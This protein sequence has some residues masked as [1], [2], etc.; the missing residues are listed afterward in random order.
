MALPA[1]PRLTPGEVP[2]VCACYEEGEACWGAQL[3]TIGDWRHGDVVDLEVDGVRLRMVENPAWAGLRAGNI[4]ALLPV[5]CPIPPVAVM[6]DVPAVYGE[7]GPLLVDLKQIPGRGV[8]VLGDWLRG[9]LAALQGGG[10]DFDDL[11]RGMDR[12][13]MYQG[14]G[15]QPAFPTPTT[16]AS[17]AFPALPASEEALLVRTCFEDED[18][19]RALLDQFGGVD[20]RGRIGAGVEMNSHNMNAF[21]L[22]AL[23]VDDWRFQ[24][25]CPGQVPA[26]VAPTDST[27]DEGVESSPLVLLADARTFSE[28]GGPLTAVDLCD[29]PGM[30]TAVPRGAVATMVCDVEINN[31]DFCDFVAIGDPQ[32]FWG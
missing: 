25:L 10:L 12:Y 19:W 1:I 11:V 8:R 23:A 21:P 3:D 29:T 30:S 31:L 32:V 16:A 22:R 5:G 14:D 7:G 26:L 13:G 2:W 6:A 18:G 27:A 4:P 20:E 9:I 24:G 28:P 17:R 15:G